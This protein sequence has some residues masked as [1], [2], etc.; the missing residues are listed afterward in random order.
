MPTLPDA[1]FIGSRLQRGWQRPTRELVTKYGLYLREGLAAPSAQHLYRPASVLTPAD[2]GRRSTREGISMLEA[3]TRK[4]S[5]SPIAA[6]GMAY[7][8]LAR[9]SHRNLRALA[10]QAGAVD[11]KAENRVESIVT[12]HNPRYEPITSAGQVLQMEAC[13]SAPGI[14]VRIMR[15]REIMLFLPGQ[16]PQRVTG[17]DAWVL[18]H[19]IDHLDGILCTTIAHRQGRLMYYVPPEWATS[20]F[21]GGFAD[22]WPVFPAAQYTAMRRG[23]FDLATFARYL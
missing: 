12:L 4:G 16:P 10:A 1:E 11:A 21:R 7:P 19:E 6:M 2:L 3:F 20:F 23:S 14:G 15:W 8:Q 13:F 22:D 17:T 9:G 18:Q 5:G